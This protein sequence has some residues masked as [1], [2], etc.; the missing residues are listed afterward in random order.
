MS[1]AKSNPFSLPDTDLL[2]IASLLIC[3]FIKSWRQN[4]EV[5]HFTSSAAARL[6]LLT[7]VTARFVEGEDFRLVEE[8]LF[9]GT[10]SGR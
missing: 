5:V 7:H 10:I 6:F 4:R 2:S 1:S 8:V 9:L 3:S